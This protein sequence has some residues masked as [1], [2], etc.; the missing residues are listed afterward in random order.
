M[1]WDPEAFSGIYWGWAQ[2]DPEFFPGRAAAA[3]FPDASITDPV[4]NAATMLSMVRA[5]LEGGDPRPWRDWPIC[6]NN[7]W[8][9]Y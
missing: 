7:P 1:A 6:G 9:P 4:A 5:K 3:G 8:K 2:H